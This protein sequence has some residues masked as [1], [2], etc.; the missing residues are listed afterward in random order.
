MLGEDDMKKIV[1]FAVFLILFFPSVSHAQ[2]W[3]WVTDTKS[4]Q[5]FEEQYLNGQLVKL[6]EYYALTLAIQKEQEAIAEKVRF[7]HMVRDSL[8]KS[9]QQVQGISNSIDER[10][11][12]KIYGEVQDYY[13]EIRTL[14]NKHD[15]FK[16]T[17]KQ[18][19][20]HIVKR[21]D[22]VLKIT[23]MAVRGGDEKNLLD[24]EQRLFLLNFA[25]MEVRKMREVSKQTY[26]N[27]QLGDIH[28]ENPLEKIYRI[29]DEVYQKANSR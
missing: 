14:A 20:E 21:A 15:A 8:F 10:S 24:K 18:Y 23:D 28:V 5:A 6:Y 17:W 11:I 22:D 27:L 1:I 4:T 9:L 7:I 19:D 25:L 26:L 12:H 29:G 2:Y 16:E 13:N 3:D